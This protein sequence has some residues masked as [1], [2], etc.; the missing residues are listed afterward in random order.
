[1]MRERGNVFS[2]AFVYVLPDETE[3]YVDNLDSIKRSIDMGIEIYSVSDKNK[4]DPTGKAAK[5]KPGKPAIYL[6]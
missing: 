4:H 1:M 3:G 5:A 2:K 6:E